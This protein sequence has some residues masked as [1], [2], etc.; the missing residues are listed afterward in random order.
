MARKPSTPRK[1]RARS[2]PAPKAETPEAPAVANAYRGEHT[3]DLGGKTYKLRPTY[4]AIVEMEDGTGLSLVDLTRRADRHGLKLGE[5]A[6]VAT[7]LI[8]A[9]ASDPLT[10]AVSAER[11]GELIYEQG[12][13]SVVIRLTLCLGEAVGGG[14]TATGEA[15]AA[16][17]PA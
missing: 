2:G 4:D 10:A 15:K 14:R 6:K 9:G 16:I 13:I 11:I 5:A 3:L 8:K 7:A 17:V 1:S 12:L